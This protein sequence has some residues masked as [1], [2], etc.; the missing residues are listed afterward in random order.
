MI[1]S[2]N[3]IHYGGGCQGSQ[4]RL[5]ELAT[6]NAFTR[7]PYRMHMLHMIIAPGDVKSLAQSLIKPKTSVTDDISPSSQFLTENK[8]LYTYQDK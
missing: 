8:L 6:C 5:I 2:Y 3:N 7:D 4:N 1:R